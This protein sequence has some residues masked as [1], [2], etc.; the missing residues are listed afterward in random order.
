MANH[1]MVARI[2]ALEAE[3]ATLKGLMACGHPKVCFEFL[4]NSEAFNDSCTWCSELA[5][6]KAETA[7][8][9]EKAAMLAEN[10][11]RHNYEADYLSEPIRALIPADH[12]AALAT[13]RKESFEAGRSL[14]HSEARCVLFSQEDC[15]ERE[16]KARL[17]GQI[18]EATKYG[19]HD[20]FSAEHT[21]FQP[22]GRCALCGRIAE[23]RAAVERGKE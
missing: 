13:L 23:L 21:N 3:I 7:A 11:A 20:S 16:R 17:E 4:V 22:C 12:A 9:L 2:D 1:Y 18:E 14:G 15:E 6:L 19:T 8:L 5:V 10:H